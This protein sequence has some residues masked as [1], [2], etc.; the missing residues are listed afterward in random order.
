MS[1]KAGFFKLERLKTSITWPLIAL[2]MLVSVTYFSPQI[3]LISLNHL[4]Q[5]FIVAHHSRPLTGNIVIVEIDDKSVAQLGRWPWRRN[6]HASLINKI[7]ADQPQAIGLDILFTEADQKYPEDDVVL[8]QAVTRNNVVLPILT[9]GKGTSKVVVLPITSFHAANLKLPPHLGH[10]NL[11][12]DDD[13]V[14]RSIFLQENVPNPVQDHAQANLKPQAWNHFSL[15]LLQAAGKP[16]PRNLLQPAKSFEDTSNKILIPYAGST[17]YFKRVS[18][19]DVLNDKLSARTFTN[20]IVIVAATASGVGDQ[21]TTPTAN[22]S[23][24]MPGV[25][26][27]ANVVDG[28]LQNKHV[29]AATNYQNIVLNLAFVLVALLAFKLLNPLTALITT[30]VLTLSL[31]GFSYAA[32]GISGL[33][34]SPAAGMLGLIAIYPLWSWHRLSAATRYLTKEF[35]SITRENIILQA[36]NSPLLDDFL[37]KRISAL[38]GATKQLQGLHRFVVESINGLPDPVLVC[39]LHGGIKIANFAAARHFHMFHAD[40]LLSQ[41]VLTLLA[42]VVESKTAQPFINAE[43]IRHNNSLI[44]AEGRDSEGRDLILKCAPVLNG[45]YQ[46][47]G[48]IVSLV[49]ISEMLK[50][51]R[52]RDEAFR[53]I[54]HDIRSPLSSIISLLELQRLQNRPSDEGSSDSKM[55]TRIER[56]ADNALALADDFMSLSSAKSAPYH[57]EEAD[58][59]DILAQAADEVWTQAE[60]RYIKIQTICTPNDSALAKIEASKIQ[61]ALTNLISN[62]VKFSPSIGQGCEKEYGKVLCALSMQKNSWKIT[63][64]DFGL[65]MD[66]HAQKRLFQSFSRMHT[67]THPEIPGTGLGLAFVQTVIQKHGGSISV[68]SAVNQGSTFTILLPK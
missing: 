23:L 31:L 13:G 52:E 30:V 36:S 67:L 5:D 38:T 48:W 50:A 66:E 35:A 17:G 11:D 10:V 6:L 62:A 37:D 1:L 51:E 27:M 28:F 14:I 40:D 18:Y 32:Y 12:V 58:L 22:Q 29:I 68:E 7:A 65:G 59:T 63:I 8:E 43:T 47:T 25:E 64:T 53:F 3:R 24:L 33:L 46:H 15:A 26:I 41:S 54:T 56:Y 44:E 61:R 60:K 16:I 45:D 39:D 9:Q 2:L 21:Y 19:V 57:F 20:K 55:L 4:I 49:D 42:S 34:F